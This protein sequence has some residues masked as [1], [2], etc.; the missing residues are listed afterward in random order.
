MS[1]SISIT[2]HKDT[3]SQEESKAFEKEVIEK[4][5]EFAEELEGVTGGSIS[6]GNSG[7]T[8]IPPSK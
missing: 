7:T 2:G 3:S 8:S 4:T 6:T 1:Y 5:L